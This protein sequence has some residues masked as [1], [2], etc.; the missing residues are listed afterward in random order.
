MKKYIKYW[1]IPLVSM[2]AYFLMGGVVEKPLTTGE[3]ERL[4]DM[5]MTLLKRD[6]ENPRI[7]IF[8][9]SN[10]RFSHSCKVIAEAINRGCVNLSIAA[11]IGIDFLA[12]SYLPYIGSSDVI[13]MPMEYE[14]Y[15]LNKDEVYSGPESPFL[16]KR[17]P[18]ILINLGLERC[19][20]AI[21]F[22][23]FRY[24]IEGFSEMLLNKKGVK[25]RFDEKSINEYG[26]QQGHDK[27]KAASY[28]DYI[29]NSKVTIPVFKNG[30]PPYFSETV[31]S[32]FLIDAKNKK[33]RIIGGL[34]V[35]FDDVEIPAET[36]NY[37][38][39][40]YDSR[41]SDFLILKNQ[42][43][44]PRSCFFDKI[45]HLEES[46]QKQHSLLIAEALKNEKI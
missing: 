14:Q 42:S 3:I 11:G 17:H 23:D 38:R 32:N 33:A 34:P 41:G 10:G 6:V 8:A 43:R 27:I 22:P 40:F 36:I 29:K 45:Y 7:I 19:I 25:R 15:N 37:L 21:F 39:D 5:K 1:T 30:R 12:Q 28:S 44:Y 16:L 20:R 18:K 9:G 13:Y 46:C 2:F 31:I 24:F 26:D 35:V 4:Y